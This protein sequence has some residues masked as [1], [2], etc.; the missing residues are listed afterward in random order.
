ME[1]V[2]RLVDEQVGE[3]ILRRLSPAAVRRIRE[4]RAA[5]HRTVLITGALDSFVRPL[6]PL[7]DEI[8]A[9]ELRRAR[10]AVHRLPGLPP[11]VGEARAAWLRRTPQAHGVDLSGRYAYADSHSDLPMLRAVGNPVAVNPDVALFRAA[12]A[13]R[14][15]VEDWARTAGTP[16]DPGPR[17]G[18]PER[19]MLALELY[20]SVSRYLAARAVGDRMPGLLAG[21]ARPAAAGEPGRAAP[22]RRRDGPG[23]GRGCRASAAPTWR[24]CPGRSSFYFSPLVS[25]PFV[26]GH[27]VVGDAAR[28]LRRPARRAPGS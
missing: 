28:R 9:T 26:P 17:A 22:S 13:R 23:C 10:R 2:H 18:R 27:E 8:V 14:W 21:P 25:M 16:A 5:G 24:R 6:A 4:H 19:L 15:P 11:L 12:E 1:G 7:F 3:L 20:R